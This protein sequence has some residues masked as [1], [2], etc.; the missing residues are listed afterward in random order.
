MI[1]TFVYSMFAVFL[2]ALGGAGSWFYLQMEASAEQAKEDKS[3]GAR[4]VSTT[5]PAGFASL[6]ADIAAASDTLMP[7][8]I[9]STTMSPEE[10]FRFGAINRKYHE[11]LRKRED[12]IDKEKM[13]LKLAHK[14]IEARQLEIEGMLTQVNDTLTAGEKLL[15]EIKQASAKL[16]TEQQDVTTRIESLQQLEDDSQSGEQVSVKLVAG[17]IQSMKDTKAAAIIRELANDGKMDYALNL[18]AYIEERNAAKIL[19]AMDDS[20]L[21]AELAERFPSVERSRMRKR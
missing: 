21:A 9:Q 7:V 5:T 15:S 1:K 18:M 2:F 6:T 14:D 20:V 19:A 11:N 10:S 17:W 4:T 3:V 16:S 8:P 12:K 13:R